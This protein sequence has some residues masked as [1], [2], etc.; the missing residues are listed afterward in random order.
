[1]QQLQCTAYS[2]LKQANS[3]YAY[4]K[5]NQKTSRAA[6]KFLSYQPTSSTSSCSC[7]V[8]IRNIFII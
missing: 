3:G 1:M 5:G 8:T 4:A 6:M 2:M 7:I